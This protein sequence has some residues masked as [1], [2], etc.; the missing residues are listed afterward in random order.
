[1][2]PRA[3]CIL[4]KCSTTELHAQLQPPHVTGKEREALAAVLVNC[5]RAVVRPLAWKPGLSG[6]DH[7]AH[8]WTVLPRLTESHT[9]AWWIFLYVHYTSISLSWKHSRGAISCSCLPDL[10]LSFDIILWRPPPSSH[11]GD[12]VRR[13]WLYFCVQGESVPHVPLTTDPG[14]WELYLRLL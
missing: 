3:S 9:K 7:W 4:G 1:M 13:T 10:H 8:N 12:R 14:H 5:S 11:S 2:E 6:H